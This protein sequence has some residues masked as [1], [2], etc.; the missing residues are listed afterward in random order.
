MIDRYKSE[1]F[2]TGFNSNVQALHGSVHNV[3]IH[4]NTKAISQDDCNASAVPVFP[5]KMHKLVST[6]RV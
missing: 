4:F 6:E 1:R 2:I 5:R 3:I